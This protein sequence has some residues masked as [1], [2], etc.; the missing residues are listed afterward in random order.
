MYT[1]FPQISLFF[2]VMFME[3]LAQNLQ[4]QFLSLIGI[5]DYIG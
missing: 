4:L 2:V 5:D 1:E 3:I